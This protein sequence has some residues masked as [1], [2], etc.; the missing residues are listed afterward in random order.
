MKNAK[1]ITMNTVGLD[2][3]AH[4]IGNTAR[5]MPGA[6]ARGL[7]A[8]LART[9]QRL[10][11]EAKE[12]YAVNEA[13]Q[14]HLDDL[15]QKERA[16]GAKLAASLRIRKMRNDLGYFETHPDVPMPGIAWRK[17]PEDG[18]MGH[19][20]RETAMRSLTGEDGKKSKGFLSHFKSGHVGMVQRVIGSSSGRTMTA[21]GRPRWRSKNG[22]IEKLVTMGSPSAAAMINTV[23]PGRDV[24]SAEF[25][26]EKLQ[27]TMQGVMNE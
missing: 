21:R 2:A 23:W 14:R 20:L 22:K 16:S 15:R 24:E 10:I 5:V 27:E 3:A 17:A 8:T 7:N 13:G 12:R 4:G 26:L 19:V 25:F 11:E 9:R 1:T 18:F 6:V